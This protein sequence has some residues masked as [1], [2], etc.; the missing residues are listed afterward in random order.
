MLDEQVGRLLDALD[1]RDDADTSDVVV[2]ADH[3]ELLGDGGMLYKGTMLEATVRVAWIERGA[4]PIGG[5]AAPAGT[6]D[7]LAAHVRARC[8][9]DDVAMPD[10]AFVEHDRELMAVRGDCKV[11]LGE[12]AR[13]LWACDLAA[14]P[15]EMVDLQATDPARL[16]R[17]PAWSSLIAEARRAWRRRHAAPWKWWWRRHR[18][19][20]VRRG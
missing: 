15:E 7:L 10:V 5:T 3:G 14:D 20:E 19:E 12:G 1:R 6:T 2:T 11:V 16:R 8:G 13:P 9:I 4:Q 17:D 18:V